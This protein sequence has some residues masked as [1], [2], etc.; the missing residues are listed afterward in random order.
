MSEC[1]MQASGSV[2]ALVLAAAFF[3]SAIFAA[4]YEHLYPELERVDYVAEGPASARSVIYVF[5][6][7]NCYFC[8]LTWK[9]L[10]PYESAGLQVR[11][12][13]VAYQKASSAGRAAAIVE[14]GDKT[15][16]FRE[17][18]IRYQSKTYDG[19]I[20]PLPRL[21]PAT[22]TMLRANLQLMK[23]F[24]AQGTPALVWKNRNGA[25]EFLNAVPRLTQ[26]PRITG[27]PA[28]KIDDPELSDFR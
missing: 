14:A 16:A 18:E 22:A 24:G 17:N 6:D 8:H 26:L 25:V 9:A 3:S 10:Q 15:A 2:R 20:R 21:R 27:L 7:A 23:E 4:D 28:Q 5:F 11:W 1:A 19:G 13:P 12:V